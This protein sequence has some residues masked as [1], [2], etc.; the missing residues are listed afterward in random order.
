MGVKMYHYAEIDLNTGVVRQVWENKPDGF[1]A[2][3]SQGCI[4]ERFP[5]TVDVKPGMVWNGSSLSPKP[6]PPLLDIKNV[7]KESVRLYAET[8]GRELLSNYPE[9]EVQ[10]WP[11]KVTAA[12]AHLAGTATQRQTDML[13]AEANIVG[14]TIDQLANTIIAKAAVFEQAAAQ[15]AGMRQKVYAQIDAATTEAEINTILKQAKIEADTL[16]TQIKAQ[17]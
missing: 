14:V 6:S 9:V 11:V 12:E 8:I 17:L 2:P 4:L 16:L 7:A 5:D 1:S 10:S 13:T 3:V 15:I